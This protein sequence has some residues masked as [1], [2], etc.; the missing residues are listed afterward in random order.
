VAGN[1]EIVANPGYLV[2][3]RGGFDDRIL[4]AAAGTLHVSKLDDGHAR[5]GGRM[6]QRAVFDLRSRRWSGKLRV[7]A[8]GA[9][10]KRGG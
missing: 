2:L 8:Q 1:Q 10:Q 6:K 7:S 4:H 3:G 9:E 5:A